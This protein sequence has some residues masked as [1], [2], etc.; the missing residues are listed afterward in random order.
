MPAVP[1]NQC[2]DTTDVAVHGDTAHVDLWYPTFRPIKY[3][4]IGLM[5][6]RASDGIR[7]SYDFDRDGWVIEQNAPTMEPIDDTCSQQVDHWKEV[8]FCK[9]WALTPENFSE[10]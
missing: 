9:S 4:E 2:S 8:A 1:F 10:G 6:V 7:V 5:D 3:I